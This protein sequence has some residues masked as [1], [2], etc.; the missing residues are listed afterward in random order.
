MVDR[1]KDQASDFY[2][3]WME[4]NWAITFVTVCK[5]L[6]LGKER[7]NRLFQEIRA[8]MA[9]H[10][11]YEN[12][13]YSMKE[14]TDELN[15][16]EIPLELFGSHASWKETLRVEKAKQKHHKAG[17][18]ESYEMAAKLKTLKGLTENEKL[19]NLR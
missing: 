3:R 4:M 14:L 17:I 16:L 5:S 15:R 11:E 8:E 2:S 9:R 7:A 6:G 1:M 13:Q 10:N 18:A 12:Y 19:Y